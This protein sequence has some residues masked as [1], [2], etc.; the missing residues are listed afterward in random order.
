MRRRSEWNRKKP[1]AVAGLSSRQNTIE[2]LSMTV[3]T[4]SAKAS[5]AT[6]PGGCSPAGCTT[7]APEAGVKSAMCG[8]IPDFLAKTPPSRLRDILKQEAFSDEDIVYLLGLTR[9]EDCEALRRAAYDLTT[10]LIGDKVHYRGIVEFSN[11]C[12][13]NC[14]YCGIRK[15]NKA[16]P[17]Y[18]LSKEQI[19]ESALWAAENNYGSICLQAGERRDETFIRFVED[20]IRE[21]RE[22]SVSEKLPRG[23]SMTLSLGEQEAGTYRRWRDAA[24]DHGGLRYLLRM[25]STNPELFASLHPSRDGRAAEKN[26]ESRV[27]ALHDIREAG[28]QV[29]TGGMIGLPGQTLA[30]LCADIRFYDRY[31]VDMLGMGPYIVSMG[32][33]MIDEGMLDAEPLL[34]LSMNMLAVTRLVLRDVNIAAATALQTLREE[35]RELGITYGCNIVMPNISPRDVRKHYQLYDNKPCIEEERTDCRGCLETRIRSVGRRVGWN[36]WGCSRHYA[37][38]SAALGGHGTKQTQS[39]L[40]AFCDPLLSPCAS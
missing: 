34:Q 30:D 21:I 4:N 35:G 14:R 28:L 36:E 2:E 26:Y 22:K 38:R 17:R 7:C 6:S 18:M 10:R 40:A 8:V 33:D 39:S 12:A 5:P 1:E 20:C 15:S 19:V 24:G 31:D 25:E 3:A 37:E 13:L 9:P 29:G 27:R 11:I 23:L 32:A 16:V